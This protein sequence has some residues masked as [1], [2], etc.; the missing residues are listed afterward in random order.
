MHFHV[1]SMY[2][3]RLCKRRPASSRPMRPWLHCILA[4]RPILERDETKSKVLLILAFSMF[5]EGFAL[6][7]SSRYDQ[8]NSGASTERKNPVQT[9]RNNNPRRTGS[10]SEWY[11]REKGWPA[12]PP[13]P[14]AFAYPQAPYFLII[15]SHSSCYTL[16]STGR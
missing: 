1:F 2:D 11:G 3:R 7:V 10:N 8:V 6:D 9:L 4:T 12:V 13:M 15:S 5:A 16:T 14:S